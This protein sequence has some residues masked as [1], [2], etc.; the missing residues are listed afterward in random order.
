MFYDITKQI[1]LLFS[2]DRQ[3]YLF[4][5]NLLG[6]YPDDI[7]LYIEALT[8][9]SAMRK[10]KA[11]KI[12]NNERLEF[13]GDGVLDSVVAHI[14]YIKYPDK[15]E[16]FLTGMRAKIV[17]REH[18]NKVAGDLGLDNLIAANSRLHSHNSYVSGNALEAIVGAIYLD[19]GYETAYCFIET[20]ILDRSLDDFANEEVNYKSK[21]IEWT[22]KYKTTIDFELINTSTDENNSPVFRSAVVIGGVYVCEGKGYTK[23]ESHQ[24]A[25]K[26][27]YELIHKDLA[28]RNRVLLSDF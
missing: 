17:Q 1:K 25:A 3:L 19:K 27:A 10:N 16:G 14:L 4:F 13:L 18:L 6:F 12:V 28:L 9:R 7:D 22:Q 5:Y 8:H 26:Q 24:N 23:K 21:L 15:N 11:G 2:K 20:K